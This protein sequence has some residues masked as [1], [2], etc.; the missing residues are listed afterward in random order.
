MSTPPAAAASASA[1]SAVDPSP[2]EDEED[3]A[4]VPDPKR[5][6]V[7]TGDDCSYDSTQ[8]GCDVAKQS[9]KSSGLDEMPPHL[10]LA[11]HRGED[12]TAVLRQWKA[13]WKEQDE[14][15]RAKERRADLP[16]VGNM[17][18]GKVL[19]DQASTEGR[20]VVLAST[21]D[22]TKGTVFPSQWS[23]A[24]RRDAQAYLAEHTASA[25]SASGCRLWKHSNAAK[26]RKVTYPSFQTFAFAVH[27]QD[28]PLMR[29]TKVEAKCGNSLCVNQDCMRLVYNRAQGLRNNNFAPMSPEA[30]V[31]LHRLAMNNPHIGINHTNIKEDEIRALYDAGKFVLLE[32][33]LKP[34]V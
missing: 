17:M 32:Q 11:I 23:A 34:E 26:F 19:P 10:V 21:G 8:E 33:L 7:E 4:F 28:T 16:S 25:T 2:L 27:F 6:H 15:R 22:K 29:Q 13:E 1:A 3:Y 14:R 24:D 31:A 30:L 20:P 9:V 5:Q 18:D 12:L